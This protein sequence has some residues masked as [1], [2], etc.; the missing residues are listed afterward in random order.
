[1]QGS[2]VILM[3]EAFM[4]EE[5]FKKG[6]NTYLKTHLYS[7]AETADLWK[8]LQDYAPE[9]VDIAKVMDTWTRQMGFPLVTVNK[10]AL[11]N[12]IVTQKRFLSNAEAK[13]DPSESKYGYVEE[14]FC[15]TT[16]IVVV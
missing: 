5:N 14:F 6:L 15:I 9:G 12:Y 3:L 7:N 10:T 11:G 8:A 1:M 13:F 4:G 16:S 2:S